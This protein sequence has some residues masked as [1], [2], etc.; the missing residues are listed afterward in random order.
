MKKLSFCLLA[1][2]LLSGCGSQSNLPQITIDNQGQDYT[3]AI[4]QQ[5][6]ILLPSN[7]TTGYKWEVSD[8][9]S[10]SI[11]EVKNEYKLSKK[12]EGSD[13]V[14]A[15]GE[16]IWTFKV[17]SIERSRIRMQYVKSWDKSKV[18][19]SFNISING[20]PDD[21]LITLTGKIK[22][23]PAGDKY[24]DYFESND[25]QKF[26]IAPYTQDNIGDPGIRLKIKESKDSGK[27]VE[28][29]GRFV[30]G[31]VDYEGKLFAIHEFI[32]STP[33]S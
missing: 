17:V 32:T 14:G 33:T 10:S 25:G 26:G 2:I 22:S 21:G 11:E 24:D 7:Q 27:D 23:L 15:G 31:V 8:L 13:V 9:T 3:F 5:F 30:D 1:I 12:Y 4:D 28:I 29:R 19:N 20:N 16:E 18:A 6:Q